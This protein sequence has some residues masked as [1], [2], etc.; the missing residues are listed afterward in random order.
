VLCFGTSYCSVVDKDGLVFNCPRSCSEDGNYTL[1]VRYKLLTER[2]TTEFVSRGEGGSYAKFIDC[3][4]SLS[5]DKDLKMGGVYDESVTDQ[6]VTDT[7]ATVV[8]R[9]EAVVASI[10]DTIARGA[11]DISDVRKSRTVDSLRTPLRREEKR[12]RGHA[13]TTY[14]RTCM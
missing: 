3:L 6:W 12:I 2:I 9:N 11:L 1:L 13:P 5:A 14:K 4:S 8:R 7:L 10:D